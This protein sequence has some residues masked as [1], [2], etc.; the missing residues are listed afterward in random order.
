MH[1]T[2]IYINSIVTVLQMLLTSIYPAK[3]SYSHCVVL[4]PTDRHF[5]TAASVK[6][7]V[8]LPTDKTVT[9]LALVS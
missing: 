6:K 7:T 1:S 4:G 3:P 5:S 2:M 8:T 9:M